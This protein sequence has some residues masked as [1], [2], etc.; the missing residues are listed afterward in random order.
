M[1]VREAVETVKRLVPFCDVC[2][3]DC[4]VTWQHSCFVCGRKGGYCCI[5]GQQLAGE[6]GNLLELF[7]QVCTD[8]DA[9]GKDVCGVPFQTLI[10]D[11]VGGADAKAA[12]LIVRWKAWAGERRPSGRATS[13]E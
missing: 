2:G 9:A 6:N 10:R 7:V 8:C 5:H 12:E 13:T 3:K 11:A 1:G 4:P